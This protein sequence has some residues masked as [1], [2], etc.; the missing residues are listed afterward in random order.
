MDVTPWVLWFVGCVKQACEEA[1]G[2]IRSAL[3][4]NRFWGEVQVRFPQLSATERKALNKMYDVGPEGFA[5]GISTEKYVNLTGVS[6]AT[7]YREL[8]QLTEWAL[9]TKTG[10]G[11]GTRYVWALPRG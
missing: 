11:R 10:N 8:T 5:S 2:Q 4:K 1:L 3:D 6:R 7:A 9:L